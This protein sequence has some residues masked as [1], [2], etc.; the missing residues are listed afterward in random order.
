MTGKVY[1]SYGRKDHRVEH[2]SVRELVLD[3]LG[4]CV[5]L[6]VFKVIIILVGGHT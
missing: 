3:W 2:G 6:L 4:L 5:N 1:R